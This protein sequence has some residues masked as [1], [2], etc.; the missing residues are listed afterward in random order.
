[1]LTI[2]MSTQIKGVTVKDLMANCL[3][4]YKT[5]FEKAIPKNRKKKDSA[6]VNKMSVSARAAFF[7]KN[8]ITFRT[9]PR[10]IITLDDSVKLRGLINLD[11]EIN[12]ID[13]ATYK[14]LIGMIIIL[15]LNMEIIS[16]SNHRVPFIRIYE[17]VRLAVR[18]IKYE[19]Y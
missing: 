13:K 4:V 12:C 9:L 6:I 3:Y 18:P 15:S 8:P 14:Q 7:R 11:A 1:L 17:N 16:H 2:I 10:I 19:T 5:F